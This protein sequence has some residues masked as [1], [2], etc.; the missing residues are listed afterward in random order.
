MVINGLGNDELFDGRALLS[1]NF[2]HVA[3]YKY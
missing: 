3:E 2:Y 1:S